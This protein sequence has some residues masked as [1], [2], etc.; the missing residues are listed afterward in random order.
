MMHRSPSSD[1]LE[2]RLLEPRVIPALSPSKEYP[3]VEAA[4]RLL[5]EANA[6]RL[7]IYPIPSDLCLSIV[8]PIFNEEATLREIVERIQAVPIPKQIILVDDGSTDRTR[9]ILVEIESEDT[10]EV[11]YQDSNQGKGAAVRA[12][13]ERARGD[14]VL[15]QDADL[16]YDPNQYLYLI[17]PVVEGRAD[18][19]YGSRFLFGGSHRVLYFWH[20]VANRMLTTFSNMLTDL[21]LT[22]METCYKIFRREVIESIRP[23]LKQNRFGIEPELTAK[24][25]RRGYR[26]YELGISYNGRT[27]QA[28]KKIGLRDAFAALWSIA[29]Y[30]WKD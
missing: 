18:V 23:T 4:F 26:V 12:G 6:R 24:V 10:I 30:W 19:V 9:A 29:R 14:I 28:G 25:A 2:N 11:I 8:V 22:D 13:F 27:Y 3:D 15:I 17:Q 16:E 7:G 20:Y 21:N 1:P 5:G